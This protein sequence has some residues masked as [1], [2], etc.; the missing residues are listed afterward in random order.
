MDSNYISLTSIIICT[1]ILTN[2]FSHTPWK[3]RLRFK[4]AV[5]AAI[6]AVLVLIVNYTI[7]LIETYNFFIAIIIT[8]PSFL[9][10][11]IYFLYQIN[12]PYVYKSH[13]K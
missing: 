12:K 13:K 10:W 6:I 9:I 7:Q 3:D 4:I 8:L 2:K 11:L 5:Y 1:W